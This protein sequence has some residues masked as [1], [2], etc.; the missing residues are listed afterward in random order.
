MSL[1]KFQVH[2]DIFDAKS[3]QDETNFYHQRQGEPD[4]LTKK[5]VYILGSRSNRYPISMQTMSPIAPKG[6]A[7]AVTDVQFKY[8]TMGRMDKASVLAEDCG[9][10]LNG[11]TPGI[12]HGIFKLRFTDNWIKRYYI[13]E[14]ARGIQAYV[15]GDGNELAPGLWEYEVQLD[16]VDAGAFCPAS[17]LASGTLWIDLNVNV[18]ESESRS[19][20][21]KSVAP[22]QYKNQLGFTRAGMSW[23]GN[24]ANK[25]MKINVA[26][27][28]G[29]TDVWMDFFMWQFENRWLEECEHMYW[30][31]RYNR[32]ANGTIALK[33][34]LT[35]KIIPRGSGLLE[36][37]QHKS[38]Y[39]K[40]TYNLLVKK[41]GNALFGQYDTEGFSVTLY[42]GTGG[43][44]EFHNAM[45]KQGAT[46]LT[47]FS[48]V[49][50]KF[51]TGSG[52]ELMLGGFFDGFYHVDG[53]VIK[54]KYHPLFDNG[55]VALKSPRH[56]ETGLPL[57]SYRMVFIDDGNVE[58]MPNIQL[59]YEKG[60]PYL[61][62]VVTGLTPM[63]KSLQIM[64][65]F[66]LDGG[67]IQQIS[68]DVDKSSYHR[69]KSQGVQL[70][71]GNRC[72]DLQCIAG[73]A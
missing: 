15:T 59:V 45:M 40:M 50:D 19:T 68:S 12:G 66:N 30:Y 38:T 29:N 46:F 28:K 16:A 35:G 32:K 22:G 62:G 1:P 24:A 13:I 67:S 11:A 14:S 56:P 44:R 43:R 9:T 58:G 53:Y 71:R 63:P 73:L 41:I 70:L 64:G 69:F 3:L 6:S 20:E 61:H 39:A 34:R 33:D 51:V 54:I 36:Q 57:E 49:A 7:A 8:P 72:F 60:R 48:G 2:Q 21:S 52:R 10:A 23:A 25:V 47:D 4:D 18:A 26:T 17:E 27:D 31:S 5:L 42:T 65:G 55:R 37:I